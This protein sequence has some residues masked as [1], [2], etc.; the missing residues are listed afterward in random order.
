M[1]KTHIKLNKQPP[2]PYFFSY[3]KA[4]PPNIWEVMEGKW[5]NKKKSPMKFKILNEIKAYLKLTFN[6]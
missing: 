1:T 5:K 3:K 4:P 6:M 2:N